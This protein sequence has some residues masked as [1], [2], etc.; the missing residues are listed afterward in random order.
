M[1]GIRFQAYW[2]CLLLLMSM[3]AIAAVLSNP[4]LPG[5]ITVDSSRADWSGLSAYPQDPQDASGGVDYDR[6]WIANDCGYLYFRI[7]TYAGSPPLSTD[8]WRYNLFIDID[9]DRNTGFY[10]AVGEYSIGADFLIQGISVFQF[11]GSSQSTW[12]WNY[13]GSASWNEQPNDVEMSIPMSLINIS[14]GSNFNWIAWSD[15]IPFDYLPDTAN[16]GLLGDYHTYQIKCAIP[17]PGTVGLLA[18]GTIL[19]AALRR[20]LPRE[21]ARLT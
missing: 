16:L 1:G 10:G 3:R 11:A 4:V 17:E 12:A 2:V 20:H 19:A 14:W 15:S 5:T 6:I 21:G 7:L 8:G 9:Q 18:I 13:L